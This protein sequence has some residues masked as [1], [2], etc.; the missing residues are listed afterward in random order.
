MRIVN[1]TCDYMVHPLGF[2][3]KKP[4]FGWRTESDAVNGAQSAYQIQVAENAAFDS[5]ILDTGRVESGLSAGVRLDAPWRPRTRYWWRVR[6]W[7]QDGAESDWSEA[8]WFETAKYDE[9]WS[10]RWIGWEIW[11][12]IPRL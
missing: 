12:S 6:I 1:L 5:P 4:S 3:F 11:W 8:A 9:P 7:D 2:D 10:A